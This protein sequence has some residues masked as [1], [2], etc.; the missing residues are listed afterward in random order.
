MEGSCATLAEKPFSA[1]VSWL[2]EA[3]IEF[4]VRRRD[5]RKRDVGVSH[6]TCPHACR[7]Y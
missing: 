1:G 5:T 6:D 2:L 4:L 7:V 3:V